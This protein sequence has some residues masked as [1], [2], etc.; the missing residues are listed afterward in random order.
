M[1]HLADHRPSP[2]SGGRRHRVAIGRAIEG[3]PPLFLFDEPLSNLDAALR[4][5]MRMETAKRHNQRRATM[6]YVTHDQVKA[7]MLAGKII[8]ARGG[9]VLQVGTPMELYHNPANRFV[10]GFLGAPRQNFI[11]VTVQVVNGDMAKVG[12]DALKTVDLSYKRGSFGAGDKARLGLRPQHVSISQ[13][14][15][16]LNDSVA[17]T[18]RLG[19]RIGSGSP[20]NVG[21]VRDCCPVR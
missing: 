16:K 3:D 7:M 5:D 10:A 20:T 2:L 19:A 11:D 14:R 6:A 17:L 18:V 1:E 4:M 12:N 15:G 9:L 8:V 13:G 21:Q